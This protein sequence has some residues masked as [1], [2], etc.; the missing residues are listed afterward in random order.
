MKKHIEIL[1]EEYVNNKLE[2]LNYYKIMM[3][4]IIMIYQ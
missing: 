2:Q 3:I 4:N 1:K